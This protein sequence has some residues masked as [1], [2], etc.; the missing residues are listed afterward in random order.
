MSGFFAMRRA[1][2]NAG[3]EFDPSATKI[4]WKSS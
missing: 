2:L 4:F 1:T 3:R